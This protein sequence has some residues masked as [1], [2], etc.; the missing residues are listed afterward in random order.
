MQNY[1]KC[2]VLLATYHGEKYIQD[3]VDSILSQQEVNVTIFVSDDLSTDKTISIIE[4][5]S[6]ERIKFLPAKKMGSAGLNFYRL[7]EDVDFINFDYIAFAD[8]D[9]IWNSDKLKRAIEKI[10]LNKVSVYSSNVLAFWESGKEVILS[11]AGE[12]KKYDYM[13]SSAGP[14]CTY[15]FTQEFLT[16][17]KK[18]LIYKNKLL[19]K[20]ELHDWLVYAYARS[21][22]YS[23]YIDEYPSMKYRQHNN[24]VF[25]A[26][27]GLKMILLR[28]SQSRNGWYRNQILNISEFCEIDNEIYQKLKRNSYID[29]LTLLNK[30]NQFRRDIKGIV[31]LFLAFLVPGFK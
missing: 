5:Y 3:Q 12:Q 20:I 31:F 16:E 30:V 6:D 17:F 11:K 10:K 25:G 22:N 27:S 1:P 8:Q 19:F 13:F 26:N 2:A 18:V 7:V 9:D 24:N 29:R 4:K 21:K 23:W 14:G 15:V 28:W